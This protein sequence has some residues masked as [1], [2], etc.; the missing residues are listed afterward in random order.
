MGQSI[1]CKKELCFRL[2]AT[3]LNKIKKRSHKS[4]VV[5]ITKCNPYLY[6]INSKEKIFDTHSRLYGCTDFNEIGA[7]HTTVQ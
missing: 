6:I 3:F 7:R 4:I 2:G 5:K 1:K